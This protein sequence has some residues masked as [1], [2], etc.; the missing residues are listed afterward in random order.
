MVKTRNVQKALA[1]RVHVRVSIFHIILC[2]RYIYHAHASTSTVI[3]LP[4]LFDEKLE[5]EAFLGVFF[6][7]K[8]GGNMCD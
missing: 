2:V 5:Q 8:H 3:P 1:I 6:R 7:E 4:L